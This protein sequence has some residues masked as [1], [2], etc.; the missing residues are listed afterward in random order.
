MLASLAFASLVLALIPL[1][2]LLSNLLFYRRL[3]PA[4]GAAEPLS[5]LIPARNEAERIGPVLASVLENRGLTFE[6]VV[7]DDSSTDGTAEMVKA[8]AAS[9][10][11]V[12]LVTVPALPAGWMGKNNALQFLSTQARYP[13]ALFL[14]ADV[15]LAPDGL[16][17]ISQHLSARPDLALTS[18]F[19]KQIAGGFWEQML[20][21]LIHFVLLGYLPFAGMRFTRYAAFATA[22]GQL[23][24]VKLDAYRAIGGHGAIRDRIH[25][26]VALPRVFRAK[27]F[28]TDL[29]DA[30]DLSAT[31][32]YT[33]AP[34]LFR[35]L[36][37]NAHEGM[38]TP[39]GLPVWTTLLFGGEVL[40]W[41]LAP[42]AWAT[43][44]D[45]ALRYALWAVAAG[46]LTRIV[47]AL[48]FEQPWLG[49]VLNPFSILT[50]LALQWTAFRRHRAGHRVA[51]KGRSYG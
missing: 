10:A 45:E 38:A 39:V 43:G 17:R 29:F 13:N 3:P 50:L 41:L 28:D 8:L 23:V 2:L 4:E 16:A 46:L 48:R 26:G 31:R 24:A 34:D 21:P 22:C 37:K 7:G 11:R 14:D 9:D 5:V 40:P 15:T 19:P 18:G 30:T 20:I 49:V 47:L 36:A 12:R 1:A 35:G 51:W 33:N 6:V 27:G 44:A 25:D 32:M 42:L